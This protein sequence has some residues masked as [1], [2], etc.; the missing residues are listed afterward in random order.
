MEEYKYDVAFSFLNEDLELVSQVNELIKN[1]LTTFIYTERQNE[2]VG[3]DGEEVFSRV[4][5]KESRVVVIFYR[6]NWG[7]NGF[8]KIEKNAIKNRAF[9]GN[10]Y[11]NFMLLVNL[12]DNN[13]GISWI[14]KT[15][16]YFNIELYGIKALVA[17]IEQLVIQNEGIIHEETPL[18]LASRLEKKIKVERERKGFLDSEEGVKV[19]N[20]EFKKLCNT[21]KNI[22]DNISSNSELYNGE[23]NFLSTN[24]FKIECCALTLFCEWSVRARNSL[25]NSFL[26][27]IISD[28]PYYYNSNSRKRELYEV[29]Y[30][31]CKNIYGQ[32]GW[33]AKE[34]ANEF[35][36]SKK[37]AD[38]TIKKYLTIINEDLA[39]R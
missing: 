17:I 19:A 4:F 22:F 34:N 11:H 3:N 16:I 30:L 37:L 14:P 31:F 20:N 12:D 25:D 23:I 1:R 8:T 9:S 18:E 2:L 7:I 6:K 5:G 26:K 39:K 35:H 13:P 32:I 10:D 36:S 21:M 15:N 38:L 28:H 24:L 27:I 33:S 29:S